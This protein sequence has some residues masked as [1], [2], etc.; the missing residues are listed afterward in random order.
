MACFVFGGIDYSGVLEVE[1]IEAGALPATT[2]DLR[3][4]AGRDGACLAGNTLQPLQIKVKARLATDTID[5]REIQRL[6][7]VA[8]A[9]LRTDEPKP[10]SLTEGIYRMAVLADESPLEFRTYS[11]TAELTFL[12]PDPIAYGVERTITVPSGGSATFNVGGS[13]PT[14]PRISADAVRDSSSQVWGL[15]LDDRD[16]IHV[17]TGNAAARPVDIDCEAR[18]CVVNSAAAIPTLDSDWLEFAPGT[19]TLVMDK[20]TGAATVTYTERWL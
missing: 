6:W 2:P 12:C 17:A 19:H 7:A 10:L 8:A 11:A 15:R 5:E 18:T 4:A 1:S 20:G 13:Y 9:G 3:Y 14:R 16:Y